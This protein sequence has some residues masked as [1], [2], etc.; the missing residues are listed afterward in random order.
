[1]ENIH[2]KCFLEEM[3]WKFKL[4]VETLILYIQDFNLAF[5]IELT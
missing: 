3:E 1:M 4:I 5:I 2:G